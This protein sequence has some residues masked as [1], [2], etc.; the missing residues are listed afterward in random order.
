MPRMTAV[1]IEEKFARLRE[2]VTKQSKQ[3]DRAA[4]EVAKSVALAVL[5]DRNAS[6]L[7]M[8]TRIDQLTQRAA[9]LEQLVMKLTRRISRMERENK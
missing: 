3:Q 7:G 2:R 6:W 8:M 4:A 9:D 1:P 5:A